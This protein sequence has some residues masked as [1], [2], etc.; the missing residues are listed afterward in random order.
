LAEEAAKAPDTG[1]AKAEALAAFLASH[2]WA[3]K[4]SKVGAA[5]K[6]TA[7]RGKEILTIVWTSGTYDYAASSYTADGTKSRKCLNVSAA[8]SMCTGRPTA[9]P[10]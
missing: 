8:K 1:V 9:P 7:K 2:N 10:A 3:F 5:V 4:V 6:V